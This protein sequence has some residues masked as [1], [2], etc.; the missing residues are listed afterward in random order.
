VTGEPGVPPCPQ[1]EQRVTAAAKVMSISVEEMWKA[2]NAVGIENSQDGLTILD[3]DTTT[4]GDAKP[5]FCNDLS[6]SGVL[7]ADKAVKIAKFKAGWS[8]LKGRVKA[9]IKETNGVAAI[10]E[11]LKPIDQLPDEKLLE[12]YAQQGQDCSDTI[13]NRLKSICHNRPFVV[14][15]DSCTGDQ[16]DIPETL[17]LLRIARRQDTPST[18]LVERNGVKVMVRPAAVGEF[19]NAWLE[20]C[21]I[22][23]DTILVDGYCEKCQNSWK[24]IIMEDRVMVRVASEVGVIDRS[25]VAIKNWIELILQ[26]S[27][28][29]KSW[30]DSL[31]PNA[32]LRYNELKEENKLPILRRKMSKG[33]SCP[34]GTHKTY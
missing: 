18:W 34:F 9:E 15:S 17:K 27:G 29:L 10:V 8:I 26:K 14:F 30:K 3:A 4:E 28:Y 21:P 24:G 12:K 2:L 1:L 31:A 25:Y 13:M 11:S 7:G 16:V 6:H 19:P 5:Y 20:D 22:H 33:Q 23:G 32:F